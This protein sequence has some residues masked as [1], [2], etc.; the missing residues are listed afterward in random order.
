MSNNATEKQESLVRFLVTVFAAPVFI[1]VLSAVV[2][3]RIIEESNEAEQRR[4][5]RIKKALEIG[6]R[7]RDFNGRL[8]LLKTKMGTFNNQNVRRSPTESEMRQLQWAFQKEYADAYSELDK[9]AWWWYWDLEREAIFF[10]L[11]SKDELDRLHPLIDAYGQ[12]VQASV[13]VIAPLWQFLSSS[14]YGLDSKTQQHIQDL[15]RTMNECSQELSEERT[16]KL[17]KEMATIFARSEYEP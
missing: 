1:A 11:L 4:N 7:N 8:N 3:P 2:I 9:T 13:G 17:A 6:D 16:N 5:T 10:D 14:R 12:N 15:Q